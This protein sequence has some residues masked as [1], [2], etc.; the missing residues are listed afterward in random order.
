MKAANERTERAR[1]AA[2]A[3]GNDAEAKV[4]WGII[5]GRDMAV[6]T[7][8]YMKLVGEIELPAGGEG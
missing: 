5:A 4:L 1:I 2:N 6:D 8:R 3:A 7:Y